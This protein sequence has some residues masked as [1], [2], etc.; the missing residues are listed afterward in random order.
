[1]NI[2][3]NEPLVAICM[4][5]F[6]PQIELFS[7]QV[8]SII[9]QT[10]KNWICIIN[11]DCSDEKIFS[12]I[13]KIVSKDERFKVSKNSSNLGFYYNF[14]KCLTYVPKN[15]DFIGFCDQDDFWH[16]DKITKT[17]KKFD[18]DTNLVYSDMNIIDK[19]GK[20]LHK[21]YWSNRKNNFK[22]LDLLIFAN[23]VTGAASIFRRNLLDLA[24]P[25]PP[26]IGESY[27]DWWIAC[28]A[29][30][31][32]KIKFIDE[33]LY[34]YR[35]YEGNV[36]G[37]F[38][39]KKETVEG[40]KIPL[41]T[42]YAWGNYAIYTNDFIRVVLIANSLKTRCKNVSPE[43][44]KIIN[45]IANYENS[46]SGLFWRFLKSFFHRRVTLGAESRLFQSHITTKIYR[47]YVNFNKNK[48]K[49]TE[50][51]QSLTEKS[52]LN[53]SIT[54]IEQKIAPLNL[55]LSSNEKKR[56]NIL[57]PTI[58]F[59][60][61]FGGYIAKFNFA[62]KI[63]LL[64]GNARIIIVDWC[65][66][67]PAHW[68]NEIQKFSGLE[69]FFDK[70]EVSYGFDRNQPITITKD[71]IFVA[72]T[73]WT[74]HIAYQAL[75]HT[76]KEKFLYL[77]QEFEPFTFPHGTY[78]ALAQQTYDFPH[79]AFFSTKFLQ[80][81]FKIKKLGVYKES[82]NEGD[83]NSA[84]FN[85]AITP[86]QINENEIKNREKFKVLLYARPES[87]AAR[88]MFELAIMALRKVVENKNLISIKLEFH[89]IGSIENY[90]D[91]KLSKQ[92][93]LKILPRLNVD[94]YKRI[95][96][97][98]D[99]GISLMLTPHPNLVTI[100][101]ASA[102]MIVVTNS[103]ENKTQENLGKISPN[104]IAAEPTLK[105]IEQAIISAFEKI[106]LYENR[107]KGSKVDWPTS[108]NNSFNPEVMNKIK[109]FLKL[110]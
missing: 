33:P 68:K 62:K 83:S 43:K 61:F 103:Y 16:E 90:N 27:H 86:I 55:Q 71:D 108:W 53:N 46:T 17:L 106:T 25:F 84:Y 97:Q 13:C 19:N 28:V 78:Y 47:R 38:T 12:K 1:M 45:E 101:M 8:E 85:N 2:K 98:Y 58:D 4:A 63:S 66:F 41:F 26:R 5:T 110:E 56:I 81:F 22:K 76:E 18:S 77:I 34:D 79:F 69:D 89:G 82:I 100:E 102:G 44:L 91:V 64:G 72:T 95:L 37:H 36:L 88:N 60:Y 14:E 93:N 52:D 74:A 42:K 109:E 40:P 3:H 23:T 65:D 35:Q 54:A 29:L 32:G 67:K 31:N 105:G 80:E 50:L 7:K 59:N 48:Y 96:P 20:I 39:G 70:V 99:L 57:I 24:F 6:N 11:D 87:H 21:T 104:I 30:T 10:H 92:F 51:L 107:I 94:E 49:R 15:A 75:K 9:Q 73:W